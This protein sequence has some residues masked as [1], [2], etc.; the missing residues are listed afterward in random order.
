MDYLV[1]SYG[2]RRDSI[3]HY[4]YQPSGSGGGEE[5][6]PALSESASSVIC[7]SAG[8]LTLLAVVI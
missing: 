2:K 3:F 5:D 6:G 8:T 7:K 1:R 4:T